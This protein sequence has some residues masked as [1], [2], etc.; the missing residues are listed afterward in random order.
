MILLLDLGGVPRPEG[1]VRPTMW[2]GSDPNTAFSPAIAAAS[3]ISARSGP[4]AAKGGPGFAIPGS[5]SVCSGRQTL[6][7]RAG[8]L[9]HGRFHC[10]VPYALETD[11]RRGFDFEAVYGV[12][13]QAEGRPAGA[14][15]QV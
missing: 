5:W 1:S 10:S 9:V 15:L 12:V 13:H 4:S 11:V 14:L 3:R 7:V 6:T 8:P 2:A